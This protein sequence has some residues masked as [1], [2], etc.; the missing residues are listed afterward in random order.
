M[1]IFYRHYKG[2][3]YQV[4]GEALDTQDDSMVI[5]Y[6]TLYSSSY[7]LFTR[8]KDVFFG[9]VR[10]EDGSVIARFEAVDY[11]DLPEEARDRVARSL[12]LWK[13]GKEN[14][15]EAGN[16]KEARTEESRQ[17]FAFPCVSGPASPRP[18]ES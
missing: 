16:Q 9:S 7:S 12:P 15:T 6:R 8:P 1:H 5:V 3:Y 4:V 10:L 13:A 18:H 17:C 11:A 2:R 14:D